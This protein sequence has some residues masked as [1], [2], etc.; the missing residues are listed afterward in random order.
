MNSNLSLNTANLLDKDSFWKKIWKQRALVFMSLPFIIYVI[1]F[2][3]IPI[4]GWIIAFQNYWPAKGILE[5]TW[6]GLENFRMLFED[7][8][9]YQI[10]RNTLAMSIIKLVFGMFFSI[11]LALMLNE[12]RNLLFKKFTQTISY[13]P[14]FISWV[15]GANL[16][17]NILSTDGGIINNILLNLHIIDKPIMFMGIPKLFW[18]VVGASH[19]W[20]TVGFG[21]ILYL[22][23][24]TSI[25]PS[26]Y[27]AATI[28]GASRLQRIWYIT[29]PGIKPVI[30]ILFI[31]NIGQLMN[32]GFEQIYLL[33]N[34]RVIEYSRIFTIFELDYGLKMMRYSFA[35]A[36]GIFRSVVSLVLVFGANHVAK[37]MGEER[38]I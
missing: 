38:L 11:L 27:E 34:G 13:L 1:I 31:M 23:S 25:S 12:V 4:W 30:I 2:K 21:A 8:I 9:F 18:W 37:Q 19:V 22:A 14:H 6:V 36:V 7:P 20:K 17:M 15:V 32:V 33:S 29:L 28:D 3:Y 5:Q 16:V 35:T 10:L 24:M 26:L